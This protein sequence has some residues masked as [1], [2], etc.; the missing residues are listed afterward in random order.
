MKIFQ[1]PSRRTFRV[2]KNPPVCIASSCRSRQLTHNIARCGLYR[3]RGQHASE[4]L[5]TVAAWFLVAFRTMFFAN[6]LA[7]VQSS[8]NHWIEPP[9]CQC[10]NPANVSRL[11]RR[12]HI[13]QLLFQLIF[14]QNNYTTCEI[15]DDRQHQ[16]MDA[17][18]RRWLM[19]CPGITLFHEVSREIRPGQ[20]MSW[21]LTV[22]HI[23]SV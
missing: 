1:F 12:R 4:P 17:S 21:W 11:L 18:D 10:Q 7:P 9:K 20:H 6:Q 22:H 16:N 3:C 8:S 19:G 13:H 5:R 14:A 2:I 15:Q 23:V